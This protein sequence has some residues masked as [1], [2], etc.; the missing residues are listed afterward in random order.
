[1]HIWL[2]CFQVFGKIALDSDT[3]IHRNNNF[4][5]FPQAVMV[6]FRY[7]NKYLDTHSL[8]HRCTPKIMLNLIFLVCISKSGSLLIFLTNS[9]L[10]FTP[11]ALSLIFWKKKTGDID[12]A[13]IEC[14]KKYKNCILGQRQ[15]KLGRKWWWHVLTN[16]GSCA[17]S[18]LMMLAKPVV[19][20]LPSPTSSHSTYFAHFL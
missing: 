18:S 12:Y 4:Q 13:G 6:L 5:T 9:L 20:T 8:Y 14:K 1:M 3:A 7:S 17:L 2:K 15:G 16:P 19:L 11:K 10:A